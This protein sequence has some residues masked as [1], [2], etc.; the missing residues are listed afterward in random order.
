MQQCL[1]I[2]RKTTSPSLTAAL[3]L[4]EEWYGDILLQLH[5]FT[6]EAETSRQAVKAYGDAITHLT[7]IGYLG[8]SAP[9]WWKAAT[10]HDAVGDYEGASASFR[11]AAKQYK[12]GAEKIPGISSVFG[13]LSS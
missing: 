2:C 6:D 4:Y 9:L 8:P 12:L 13:E 5:K 7:S 3:A 10:A 1:G 11:K